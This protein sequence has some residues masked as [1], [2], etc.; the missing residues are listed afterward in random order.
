MT[1]DPKPSRHEVGAHG[2]RLG[3]QGLR[4]A[5]RWVPDVGS[6]EFREEARRQSLAVAASP[7]EAE[8]QG[9]IDAVSCWE[10]L[11]DRDGHR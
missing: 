11:A 8:D 6:P 4:P 1:T 9:F 2:Q 10:D 3:A 5:R 7:M